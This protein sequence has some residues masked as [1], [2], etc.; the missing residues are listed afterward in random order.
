MI[1]FANPP[2]SWS[3]A[4][5]GLGADTLPG[6]LE[7]LGEHLG[8]CQSKHRHLLSLHCAAQKMGGFLAGRFVTTVV[9]VIVFLG[10][11]IWLF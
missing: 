1:N 10:V 11:N 2:H 9:F 4:S 8:S 3:T 6:E 7:A 5:N